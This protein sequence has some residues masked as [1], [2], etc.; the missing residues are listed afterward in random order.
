MIYPRCDA[1][2][3]SNPFPLSGANPESELPLESKL[4]QS[5]RVPPLVDETA[6]VKDVIKR[7]SPARGFLWRGFLNL[8]S[9]RQV[10]A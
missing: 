8:S 1:D 10:F 2:E 3:N 6:S 7:T 9:A 5:F 4:V